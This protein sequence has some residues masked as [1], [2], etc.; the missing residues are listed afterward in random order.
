MSKV[1]FSHITTFKVGTGHIPCQLIYGLYPLLPI[2]YLL[3]SKPGQISNLKLVRI[4]ISCLSEL[5][6]LQE[7]HLV[8]HNLIASNQ[9]N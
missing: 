3:P 1:L 5:E 9:W 7:N 2:K 4:I 8:A 6:K